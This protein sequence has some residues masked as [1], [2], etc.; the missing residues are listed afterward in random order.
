[1]ACEEHGPP[2]S[3]RNVMAAARELGFEAKM[4]AA[5]IPAL[6][7]LNL[8]C[9]LHWDFSHFVVLEKLT[10]KGFVISDPALGRRN[11]AHSDLDDHYTGVAATFLPN[12]D[13]KPSG[14]KSNTAFRDYAKRALFSGT[15]VRTLGAMF[16]FAILLQATS[17][18]SPLLTLYVVDVVM[19]M[20]SRSIHA[21][22]MWLIVSASIG[23]ASV[24]YLRTWAMVRI[25]RL[26]D[27]ALLEG[28]MAHI[29]RLPARFFMDKSVSDIQSRMNSSTYIRDAL[30]T[31]M[32]STFLDSMLAIS[33]LGVLTYL[34]P[35]YGLLTASFAGVQIGIYAW[36]GAAM[37]N[38]LIAELK[39]Q[40]LYQSYVLELLTG[41]LT[42]KASSAEKQVSGVWKAK[43]RNYLISAQERSVIDGRIS[44]AATAV[45][46]L[47]PAALLWYSVLGYF[48]GE[49]S[50]GT[51]MALNT[52]SGM[53]LTPL[54]SLATTIRYFQTVRSH[55]D[56]ISDV[57]HHE[58][59]EDGSIDAEPLQK[60]STLEFKNVS[61]RYANSSKPSIDGAS[62]RIPLGSK[63]GIVGP[64]G[65][66]KSTLVSLILRFHLPTS[67]SIHLNGQDIANLRLESVR[68]QFG[69]VSQQTFLFNDTVRRNLA[70][71]LEDISVEDA[72]TALEAAGLS[73]TIAGLPMGLDAMIGNDGVSL[74]GGQRQRLAIA[75]ALARRPRFLILDEATSSLDS[76]TEAA[77]SSAVAA[78]E[79]T[80]IIVTHRLSTIRTC[81]HILVVEDGRISASGT[82]EQLTEESEFYAT[83]VRLQGMNEFQLA[84]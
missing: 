56:R 36:S 3:L 81:E 71:G 78:M 59:E 54:S 63:I 8:P 30:S 50:V 52:V 17:L 27:A 32:V 44:S 53:A 61:F 62:F 15:I 48:S 10:R 4:I 64:S 51:I 40:S 24:T 65:S 16:L 58:K 26:V 14:P 74:S 23:I 1:M 73:A 20:G 29:L 25:Q 77:V 12:G 41:M 5:D 80:Q 9:I 39:T 7:S 19:P 18:L 31:Y 2:Q 70:L 75:R 84:P 13:F 55:G 35:G 28:F 69:Y 67:G 49:L 47:A 22:L 45:R 6:P 79:C 60:G 38:R 66:G 83:C 72:W 57:W 11:L 21:L 82:H 68:R 37:R 46:V 33:Y 76:E 34:S 42:I 43:F